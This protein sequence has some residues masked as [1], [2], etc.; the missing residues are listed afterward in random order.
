MRV[1]LETISSC[2][3]KPTA[4]ALENLASLYGLSCIQANSSNL[5]ENGVFAADH[6]KYFQ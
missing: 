4:A 1:F 6:F 2:P 5:I 3:D